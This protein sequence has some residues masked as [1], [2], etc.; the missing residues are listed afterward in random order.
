[1]TEKKKEVKEKNKIINEREAKKETDW[2]S[3]QE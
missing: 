1:M 3:K 2:K